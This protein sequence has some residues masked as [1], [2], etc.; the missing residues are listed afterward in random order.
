MFHKAYNI[1]DAKTIMCIFDIGK[2]RAKSDT[3]LKA[4]SDRVQ[5]YLDGKL[6][7]NPRDSSEDASEE[8]SD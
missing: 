8:E 6:V 7:L 2:E 1:L 5:Y 4:I 3:R